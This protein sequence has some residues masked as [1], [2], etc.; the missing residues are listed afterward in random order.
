VTAAIRTLWK[1][2]RPSGPV[3]A[4]LATTTAA[5]AVSAERTAAAITADASRPSATSRRATP[6]RAARQA[7]SRRFVRAQ[8]WETSASVRSGTRRWKVPSRARSS[9]PALPAQRSMRASVTPRATATRP[10]RT[11]A[12]ASSRRDRAQQ[13]LDV[14]LRR[15]AQS[16]LV[17]L[18][19]PLPRRDDR[20]EP[21]P[22]APCPSGQ[23]ASGGPCR[24]PGILPDECGEGF[25]A[26]GRGGCDAI[27]PPEP[28]PDGE[29]AIPGETAC[30]EVAP[31]ATGTWGDIP[32]DATT[33]FTR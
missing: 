8:T 21:E 31:C 4:E 25:V 18:R 24:T 29:M 9:A 2:S 14:A 30:H 10:S 13:V 23:V 5:T 27:L 28:C 12:R 22:P 1:R 3:D 32:V 17:V 15:H 19:P 11:E 16:R 26:D 7:M 6:N 33:Q 20:I